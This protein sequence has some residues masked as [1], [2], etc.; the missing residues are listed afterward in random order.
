MTLHDD[1]FAAFKENAL[2]RL[3][4]IEEI[5]L[6]FSGRRVDQQMPAG[7]NGL[8]RDIHNLKGSAS[9]LG[10]SQFVSTAHRMENVL[11]LLRAQKISLGA[12][13]IDLLLSGRDLLQNLLETDTE[14]GPEA[15]AVIAGLDKM[16]SGGEEEIL[17]VAVSPKKSWEISRMLIRDMQ[18]SYRGGKHV[19]LIHYDM[20]HDIQE[21]GLYPGGVIEEILA[22]SEIIHCE[23]DTDTVGD[24]D[25]P[26]M[27]ISLDIL[28]ACALGEPVFR[29]LFNLDTHSLRCLDSVMFSN[30]VESNT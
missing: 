26:D 24:L 8:F 16:C 11:G 7:L 1:D 6:L 29:S 15:A 21:K 22:V 9:F 27:N 12:E 23:V 17:T 14:S 25:S 20:I 10:L 13:T 19:F 30:S 4:R 5:L 3:D 28:C 18:Q 2:E